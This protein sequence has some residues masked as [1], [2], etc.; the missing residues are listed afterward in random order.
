MAK[1]RMFN[2]A[3]V[4]SDAFLDMP[5]S[6]QALYFHLGMRADDEGFIGNAKMI[7]RAVGASPDDL[8]LLIAKRFLLAF[9]S[10][11]VVVKHWHMNNAIRNDRKMLTV[12]TDEKALLSIKSNNSYTERQSNDG[13]MVGVWLSDGCHAVDKR[14]SSGC[15][16]VGE[17]APQYSIDK[18]SIDKYSIEDSLN[19]KDDNIKKEKEK[20]KKEK[21]KNA[22]TVKR[23]AP[24]SVFEVKEYCESRNNGIDAEYFVD[25]YTANGWTQGKNRPIKDWKACVRTWER[26]NGKKSETTEVVDEPE[27]DAF[28]KP[29]KP[30]WQ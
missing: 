1:R 3:V 8:K 16:A 10:G 28:G 24:P 13:Q 14:L 30:R 26:R 6:A 29:I 17:M 7:Q 27:T 20:Y 2:I 18:Y 21:E 4:G 23:F 22:L 12:Y 5:A 11:V 19:N 9:D 15:Q 25:Y